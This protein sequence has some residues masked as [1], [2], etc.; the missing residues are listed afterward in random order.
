MRLPFSIAF[1]YLVAHKSHSAVN[2]ISIISMAG[3][4][5]ATVAMVVVMSV[6]NGFTDLAEGRLGFVD[7]QLKIL[8]VDGK[9]IDDA[10]S[11]AEAV[12]RVEGVAAAVPVVEDQALAMYHDRSMPVIVKG[13]PEGYD[14]TVV[15]IGCT[16]I[17]GVFGADDAPD[18]LGLTPCSAVVS[19]GV[20]LQLGTR[21]SFYDPLT[22]F[23]PRRHGRYNPAN[24]AAAFLSDTTIV[25]GITEVDQAEYDGNYIYIPLSVARDLLDLYTEG[26]A[27]EIAL[28]PGVNQDKIQECVVKAVGPRYRVLDRRHQQE[29]AFR[30]INIEKWVTLL[31]LAFILVIASF[32]IISTLSMIIIEKTGSIAVMRAMGASRTMLKQ[33]FMIQGWL[34]SLIGG[35]AGVLIGLALSLAQQYGEFIKIGGDPANL[36]VSTYPV[37]VAP[38]D[39][40]VIL[41]I[42]A[43]IGLVTGL[44]SARFLPRDKSTG[45][46]P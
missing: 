34:V 6:F 46:K 29:Q 40:L 45:G 32:N 17:D 28:S 43:V 39:L 16:V 8:P 1:R 30:M 44:I 19:V 11:L 31:M 27:V 18:S 42:V 33:V 13:L 37:R 20:A 14:G 10:D 15:D 9:F 36:A 7:P 23:V 25:S 38:V 24:P 21:P 12:A 41:A 22:L 35:V 4:A 5:V 3:V 26:S 2:I